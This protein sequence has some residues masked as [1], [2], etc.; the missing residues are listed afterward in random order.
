MA[1]VLCIIPQQSKTRFL[2][3]LRQSPGQG[4]ILFS[5]GVGVDFPLN[6]LNF[7]VFDWKSEGSLDSKWSYRDVMLKS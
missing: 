1:R 3:A 5:D 6:L 7:A 2:S 4:G